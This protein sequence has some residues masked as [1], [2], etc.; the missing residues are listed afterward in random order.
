MLED[1]VRKNN[2]EIHKLV[3]EIRLLKIK[4]NNNNILLT[5]VSKKLGLIK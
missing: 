2:D 1:E 4:L 3:S 5:L